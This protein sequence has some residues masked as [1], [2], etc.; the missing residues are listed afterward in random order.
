[1]ISRKPNKKAR[2][3]TTQTVLGVKDLENKQ[4]NKRKLES[5]AEGYIHTP[6][7]VAAPLSPPSA[8]AN[9]SIFL[10]TMI[11]ELTKMTRKIK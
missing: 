10:H 8:S 3:K 9:Y 2:P 6:P 1:M 7:L 4:N 5:L 11:Y